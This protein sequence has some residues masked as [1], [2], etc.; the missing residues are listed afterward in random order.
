[1]Q[2]AAL[3]QTPPCRVSYGYLVRVLVSHWASSHEALLFSRHVAEVV[4]V[5]S[6]NVLLLTEE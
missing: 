3:E 6:H 1:M 2:F 4:F 5:L